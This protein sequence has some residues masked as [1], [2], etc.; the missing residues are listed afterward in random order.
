MSAFFCTETHE[1]SSLRSGAYA[2]FVHMNVRISTGPV[3]FRCFD[4][5]QQAPMPSASK[6]I[7]NIRTYTRRPRHR[8][9]P[10]QTDKD[11][12]ERRGPL[13]MWHA[14]VYHIGKAKQSW[15]GW[16]SAQFHYIETERNHFLW[17]VS[18]LLPLRT[19]IAFPLSL[20]SPRRP[21]FSATNRAP[22]PDFT[23]HSF[24]LLFLPCHGYN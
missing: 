6:M 7:G 12:R 4:D 5:K 11:R 15:G 13:A 22:I 3:C 2:G 19:T 1:V 16:A 20:P 23:Q 17:H 14:F 18:L 10:L 24:L 21:L 9:T 8:A